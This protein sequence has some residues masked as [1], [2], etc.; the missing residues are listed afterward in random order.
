MT[1]D[2]T[3]LGRFGPLVVRRMTSGP[4]L[5]FVLAVEVE[6]SSERVEIRATPK[7]RGGLTVNHVLWSGE[8][9]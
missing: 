7:G 4:K 1:D 6:G 8:G 5:G 9:E 3:I 2:R